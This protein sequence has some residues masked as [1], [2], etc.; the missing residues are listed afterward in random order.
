MF[1]KILVTLNRLRDS[2]ATTTILVVKEEI[3][4]DGE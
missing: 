1:N 4:L 2:H 3:I